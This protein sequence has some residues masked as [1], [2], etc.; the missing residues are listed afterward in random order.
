M[1]FVTRQFS[2]SQ[3]C[4][5]VLFLAASTQNLFAQ[6]PAI[7]PSVDSAIAE[8]ASPDIAVSFPSVAELTAQR[9]AEAQNTALD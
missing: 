1:L 3:A 2:V 7:V 4:L 6:P 8:N 9:Q 5:V